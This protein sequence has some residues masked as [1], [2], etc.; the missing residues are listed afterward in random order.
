MAVVI[1]DDDAMLTG[2]IGNSD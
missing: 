1:D 2:I